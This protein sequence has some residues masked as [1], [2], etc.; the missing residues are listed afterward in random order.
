[1]LTQTNGLAMEKTTVSNA[2]FVITIALPYLPHL[3]HN[4]RVGTS[5]VRVS[6]LAEQH[7]V[8]H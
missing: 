7:W 1:M 2:A 3:T 5:L 4:V 6:Y 8:R